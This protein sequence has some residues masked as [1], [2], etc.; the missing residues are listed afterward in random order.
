MPSLRHLQVETV[1]ERA[2][3]RRAEPVEPGARES[4]ACERR[5]LRPG[6]RLD[7]EA[8]D[9]TV[10]SEHEDD[11]LVAVIGVRARD[12]DY[13]VAVRLG[14]LHLAERRIAGDPPAA[15]RRL[16][17]ERSDTE[18]GFADALDE[19]AEMRGVSGTPLPWPC[20]RGAAVG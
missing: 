9:E 5:R 18:L 6:A 13:P 19:D 8:L 16:P 11:E 7:R 2:G 12:D 15:Q 17:A 4:E 20:Q 3:L 14:R 10:G 1:D